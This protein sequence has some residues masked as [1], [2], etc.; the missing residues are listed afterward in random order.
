MTKLYSWKRFVDKGYE[1]SSLGDKRFSAFS[2]KMPD[3]RTIEQHYQCDI[4]GYDIG[5]TN[6]KL[7]K[8][9]PPLD[10]TKDLW[11]EYLNLWKIWSGH[12]PLLI[13][14][15]QFLA[16]KCNYIL[17]DRFATTDV[18]QAKALSTILNELGNTRY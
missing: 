8:G 1:V 10:T 12:N 5:G 9:K 18:N 2:A 14:E 4:K 6:W 3:G 16:S 15:L 11:K 7:G 17:T 13:K